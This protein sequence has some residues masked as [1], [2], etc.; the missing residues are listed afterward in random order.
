MTTPKTI[1][2]IP[3][4]RPTTTRE[5]PL[6]QI[7]PTQRLN[8]EETTMADQSKPYT[9]LTTDNSALVLVDH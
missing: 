5:A 4:D 8:L 7:Q 6:V 9:P 2:L 3:D 1:C